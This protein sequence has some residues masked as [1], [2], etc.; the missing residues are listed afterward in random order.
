ME[1]HQISN[2]SFGFFSLI[3]QRDSGSDCDFFDELIATVLLMRRKNSQDVQKILY[4]KEKNPELR[5][6]K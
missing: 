5:L 1:Q 6:V 2:L 3:I 4:I